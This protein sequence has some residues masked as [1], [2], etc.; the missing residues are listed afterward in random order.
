MQHQQQEEQQRT[1][2][3]RLVNEVEHP[4]EAFG[5]ER[6]I[7]LVDFEDPRW[8]WRTRKL[9]R[10]SE[11]WLGRDADHVNDGNKVAEEDAENA[12][13]MDERD[14]QRRGLAQSAVEPA[15]A[16]FG[17]QDLGGVFR[18]VKENEYAD[19]D[20]SACKQRLIVWRALTRANVLEVL[21]ISMDGDLQDCAVRFT[22]PRGK[23]LAVDGLAWMENKGHLVLCVCFTDGDAATLFF[24]NHPFT[25]DESRRCFPERSFLSDK[26]EGS[27]LRVMCQDKIHSVGACCWF[28]DAHATIHLAT[29][30]DRIDAGGHGVGHDGVNH[31]GAGHEGAG[32]GE[33]SSGSSGPPPITCTV[34]PDNLFSSGRSGSGGGAGSG[35][36]SADHAA[37]QLTDTSLTQRLWTGLL[38]RSTGGADSSGSRVEVVQLRSLRRRQGEND[39][40]FLF[41]IYSD[42]KARVWSVSR[43]ACRSEIDLLAAAAATKSGLADAGTNKS[44]TSSAS[45]SSA[46]GHVEQAWIES[47]LGGAE[48]T[49]G[50]KRKLVLAVA[51]RMSSGR[52][53][54]L[55]LDGW[56]A[57]NNINLDTNIR[58]LLGDSEVKRLRGFRIVDVSFESAGQ[59]RSV[60]WRPTGAQSTMMMRHALAGVAASASEGNA[61]LH[62]ISFESDR[63]VLLEADAAQFEAQRDAFSAEGLVKQ[64]LSR[65]DLPGRFS[66]TDLCEGLAS[67]FGTK[68]IQGLHAERGND[69]HLARD[70]VV[71]L[72][73]RMLRASLF[74][75]M[76][77]SQDAI[78]MCERLID[79][80]EHAWLRG[81]RPLCLSAS[82]T[83][84]A[85]VVRRSGAFSFC[86]AD[87]SEVAL[88]GGKV[89]QDVAATAKA[90]N[91]LRTVLARLEGCLVRA[92]GSSLLLETVNEHLDEMDT[93]LLA[94][95]IEPLM[96]RW[97]DP[98]TFYGRLE[99]VVGKLVPSPA[100]EASRDEDNNM[101]ENDDNDDNATMMMDGV[102]EPRGRGKSTKSRKSIEAEMRCAALKQALFARGR[103]VLG[104]LVIGQGAARGALGLASRQALFGHIAAHSF[105]QRAAAACGALLL[106]QLLG[107]ARPCPETRSMEWLRRH[108]LNMPRTQAA[109]PAREGATSVLGLWM[110][111]ALRKPL[112]GAGTDALVGHLCDVRGG[113]LPFADREQQY[114]VLGVLAQYVNETTQPDDV[115]AN[116]QQDQ[117]PDAAYK[118]FYPGNLGDQ[119]RYTSLLQAKARLWAEVK[120]GSGAAT[121]SPALLVD[122]GASGSALE[123]FQA[124]TPVADKTARHAYYIMVMKLFEDAQQRREAIDFAMRAIK[125]GAGASRNHDDGVLCARLF[126]LAMEPTVR[127][128][129][130]ALSAARLYPR[131]SDEGGDSAMDRD[132]E[133]EDEGDKYIGQLVS[134]MVERGEVRELCELPF[135]CY[136]EKTWKDVVMRTLERKTQE[137]TAL[138]KYRGDTTSFHTLFTFCIHH[139][140]YHEAAMCM[141]DLAQRLKAS[142]QANS[143]GQWH[144]LQAQSL[145]DALSSCLMAL[146]LI[147]DGKATL[148]IRSPD[149]G[150]EALELAEVEGQF[151]VAAGAVR[152]L[153]ARQDGMVRL[154]A[155]SLVPALLDAGLA[156]TATDLIVRFKMDATP[157]FEYL[158][159]QCLRGRQP[160]AVLQRQLKVLDSA[161]LSVDASKNGTMVNTYKYHL[162]VLE[163]LLRAKPDLEL[164]QWLQASFRCWGNF[165]QDMQSPD[166][167]VFV[168]PAGSM[169]A[170]APAAQ[171]RV[172][173]TYDRLEEAL[174]LAADLVEDASYATEIDS[175]L[176]LPI[177]TLDILITRAEKHS[178]LRAGLD[179]LKRALYELASMDAPALGP[180]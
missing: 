25:D 57:I 121:F 56:L 19:S 89:D 72:A 128:Y 140:R 23:Q 2:G 161:P 34:F 26:G 10:R 50:T 167:H 120:A 45:G 18:F 62:N 97:Q 85:I 100:T 154:D 135:Q 113:M 55:A 41:A 80:C 40:T 30:P 180:F 163:T 48:D 145:Q 51:L 33:A 124:A 64:C 91:T 49:F 105:V 28:T 164:P 78:I 58:Q 119:C 103:I 144:L 83:G 116:E 54:L 94:E 93:E 95:A 98:D 79:D 178:D 168:R 118:R 150:C 61:D 169:A 74:Q 84:R 157:V 75:D 77:V 172:L 29:G 82:Q 179:R 99:T 106:A 173:I 109:G 42:G 60:W 130:A 76:T 133:F 112:H 86:A 46:R 122:A 81:H 108:T 9:L 31:E 111:R 63:K 146:R 22:L 71:G 139:A 52:P 39:E 36:A 6:E 148:F 143:G 147:P 8:K 96:Q 138:P 110:D 123:L 38:K 53:L 158:S 151:A 1:E 47:W 67:F 134:A 149:A 136:S 131:A 24:R 141:Y 127:D 165:S 11:G 175:P 114:E 104:A 107:R 5:C 153:T 125:L 90:A 68:A 115:V 35:R 126:A 159:L 155:G 7:P 73:E 162:V 132:E 20:K 66:T 27:L 14:A 87:W 16:A 170:R 160:W 142:V 15:G 177:K 171:L 70:A 101:D 102:S 12:D 137:D 166:E 92:W 129:K 43:R 65:L 69:G 88:C 13:D 176:V 59:A 21:D 17:A 44:A 37:F 3:Q 32:N 152:L 4:Q 156:D 174:A 117:A